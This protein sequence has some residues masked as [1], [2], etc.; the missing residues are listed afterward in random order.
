MDIM[1]AAAIS[2]WRSNIEQK[3]EKTCDQVEGMDRKLSSLCD[4][5]QG[6]SE[7]E[8]GLIAEH[9]RL[10][11]AVFGNGEPGLKQQVATLLKIQGWIS[12]AITGIGSLLFGALLHHW[13]AK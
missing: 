9:V 11:K 6:K 3:T 13:L 1:D 7:N 10:R 2:Q 5:L 4:S 8:P 12:H